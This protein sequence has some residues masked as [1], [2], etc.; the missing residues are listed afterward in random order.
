[1]GESD[2]PELD[3]DFCVGFESEAFEAVVELYVAEDRFGLDRARSCDAA[4][5]RS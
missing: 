3:A 2:E 1:M 5:S 4:P